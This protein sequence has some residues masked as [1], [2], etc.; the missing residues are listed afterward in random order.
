MFKKKSKKEEEFIEIDSS[1]LAEEGRIN[2][3]VENLKDYSDVERIQNLVREGN[4]V[5]LKIRELKSK[6]LNSL[7]KAI[8]RIRKTCTAINGD[9]VGID[10]DYIVVCPNYARIFRGK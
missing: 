7:K 9:I 10:E 3:R 1:F 6:D 4:I 2:V 8:E 5:F